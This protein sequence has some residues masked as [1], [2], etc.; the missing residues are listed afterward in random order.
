MVLPPL[1]KKPKIIL[2]FRFVMRY[3]QV[4]GNSAARQKPKETK[5]MITVNTTAIVGEMT[6]EQLCENLDRNRVRFCATADECQIPS[7]FCPSHL[8]D[9]TIGVVTL[10][11]NLEYDENGPDDQPEIQSKRFY[12]NDN[13]R[14]DILKWGEKPERGFA[15]FDEHGERHEFY[16]L[17]AF[18]L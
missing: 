7:Q 14:V 5:N 9:P 8:T 3:T 16:C 15:L 13:P 1:E 2:D 11:V 12:R 18:S 6:I 10:S 4:G 17:T